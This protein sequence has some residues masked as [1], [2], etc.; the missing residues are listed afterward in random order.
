MDDIRDSFSG[1][2]KDLK[3]RLGGRKRK[4]NGTGAN[5][6]EESGDPSGSLLRPEPRVMDG[7]HNE[8]SGTSTGGRQVR[9]RDQSSQP[10]GGSDDDRQRREVDIDGRQV[11][12]KHSRV[13]IVVGS[14]P[15]REVERV[16]PSTPSILHSK[17]TDSL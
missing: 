10:A 5:A 11:S 6:T 8:G 12:Q 9:L 13:G 14:G 2:K 16:Y 1:L 17:K 3:R 4:P 15:G 7:G